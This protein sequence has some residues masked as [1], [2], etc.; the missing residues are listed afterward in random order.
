[1]LSLA[2]RVAIVTG[3]GGGLGRA[4][5]TALSG[6][7]AAVSVVDID[8]SACQRTAEAIRG[9][10]GR[11]LA[12]AANV[13]QEPEIKNVVAR[14]VS[15]WGRLDILHNNAAEMD[16]EVLARDG[17]VLDLD[18]EL[19]ARVFAVNVI[20]YA[21]GAKHAIPHMLVHGGGV[22]INT[23]S[24]TGH[25]A[26]LGR[27]M[28]GTTKSAIHGLTRNIATQHGKQGIRCV[29]I[30]PGVIITPGIRDHLSQTEIDLFTEHNALN[31]SGTAEDVGSLIA[32]LAGDGAGFITGS[33]IVIDGGLL[34]HF[35]TVADEERL[36]NQA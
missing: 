23:A 10:G 5:A 1:V 16:P 18:P 24:V 26:E 12:L 32:Y 25:S 8:E 34:A 27:I 11:A 20:G 7:G 6:A 14:T 21:L 35:P 3:G 13:A 17:K 4:S 31:R 28:Y 2:G 15:E 30:S 33:D 22:V 36:R 19:F 9:A 29:S